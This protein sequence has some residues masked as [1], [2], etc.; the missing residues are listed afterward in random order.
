LRCYDS[1]VD[2]P[3]LVS[4]RAKLERAVD[5]F[6]D[7][8]SAITIH[9]AKDADNPISS[10]FDPHGRSFK[11]PHNPNPHLTNWALIVGDIIHNLRCALDHLVLQLALV[12]GTPLAEASEVTFFPIC[13]DGPS[14]RSSVREFKRC[15]SKEALTALKTVQPYYAS[16]VRNLPVEASVLLIISK[17]DNIDKHRMLVV[18]EEG[19]TISDVTIRTKDG[20]VAKPPIKPDI[21]MPMKDSAEL[22]SV[23]FSAVQFEGQ[24][25]MSMD[26]HS[27][28]DVFLNEPG[29]ALEAMRLRTILPLCIRYVET[30]VNSFGQWFF[31]E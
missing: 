1:A 18:V 11:L 27:S 29:L 10:E 8:G 13:L 30:I 20:M 4:V 15:I 25:E 9:G 3:R 16:K 23:D 28:V 19:Y 31:G 7:L 6:N 12:N 2:D 22:C 21:W 17:L 14:F 26:V 24:D 5:H